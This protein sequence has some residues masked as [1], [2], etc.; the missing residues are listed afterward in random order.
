M[1]LEV[2]DFIDSYQNE[3]AY[4]LSC[5]ELD[6]KINPTTSQQLLALALYLVVSSFWNFWYSRQQG[7]L[8]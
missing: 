2:L 5:R 8:A 7:L 3:S 4:S 1:S 6:V